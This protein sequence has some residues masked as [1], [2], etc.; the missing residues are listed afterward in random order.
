VTERLLTPS[1]VADRCQVSTKTVLRAIHRGRL[2]ASRLGQQGAYRMRA[3]D[4]DAWIESS[5]VEIA[6]PRPGH[7]A[8]AAGQLFLTPEMGRTRGGELR[9]PGA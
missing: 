3:A 2:R 7:V 8:P 6:P 1:D 4:V 9:A 5:V